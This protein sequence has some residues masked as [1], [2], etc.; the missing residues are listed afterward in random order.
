MN[1]LIML[2]YY[3]KF[4][5]TVI[6]MSSTE[7]IAKRLKLK[8]LQIF[9]TTVDAGGM[10]RAAKRLNMSQPA[11]SQAIAALW[12]C[13]RPTPRIPSLCTFQ[14]ASDQSAHFCG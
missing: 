14:V 4:E 2:F 12:P 10:M 1:S 7:T 3:N 9:M 8:D 13:C 6:A 5:W 11:V